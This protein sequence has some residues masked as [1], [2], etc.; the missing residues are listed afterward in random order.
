MHFVQKTTTLIIA[1]PTI[2]VQMRASEH[3]ADDCT[4]CTTCAYKKK[5]PAE[6][7]HIANAQ[8]KDRNPTLSAHVPCRPIN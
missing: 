2:N 5:C 3:D 8:R 7:I 1:V 4:F 6:K